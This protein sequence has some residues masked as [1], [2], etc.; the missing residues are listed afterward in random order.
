MSSFIDEIGTQIWSRG[1][2]TPVQISEATMVLEKAVSE[3]GELGAAEYSFLRTFRS[4]GDRDSLVLAAKVPQFCGQRF[5]LA[6]RVQP[7]LQRDV[8]ARVELSIRPVD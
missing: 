2:P 5:R 6:V 4:M 1:P 8:P 7:Y 3:M